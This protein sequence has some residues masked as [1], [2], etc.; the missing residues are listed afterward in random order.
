MDFIDGLPSSSGY[1]AI[2][3]MVD[4]LS[5]FAYFIPLTHPY[6]AK[7]LAQIYMEQI[8]KIHGMP[9]VIVSDRDPIFTSLFWKEFFKLSKVQLH[10]SSAYHPQTDGQTERVNRCVEAYL[11]CMTGEKPAAWSSWIHLAQWW[12]NTNFHTTLHTSPY[13]VMF[14]QAPP[15]HVPYIPGD[16]A[17][18][19]VD[20]TLA[21]RE[22]A[23][24]GI[25]EQLAKAQN[26]MKQ[27][28]DMN[29][30]EREF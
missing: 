16:S 19:A 18:E 26:R 11:R 8:Y 13:E 30:S 7:K 28:A 14:G 4:K 12:Y 21:A 27:Y 15:L 9:R 5:K 24:K 17:I 20:K 1:T 29:R 22:E 3:V 23:L 25:K 6:T 10:Y 2:W